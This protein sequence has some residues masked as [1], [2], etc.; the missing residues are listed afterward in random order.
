VKNKAPKGFSSAPKMESRPMN[1]RTQPLLCPDCG[2]K[3]ERFFNWEG[4]PI[5]VCPE[6]Y[7]ESE[8]VEFLD[9]MR[10]ENP[11]TKKE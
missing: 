7:W 11:T 6:C 3:L 2:T 4:Y 5:R 10:G 8:P 1:K 9:S